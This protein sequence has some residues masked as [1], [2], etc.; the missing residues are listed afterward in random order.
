[1][2]KDG[3][4]SLDMGNVKILSK[5]EAEIPLSLMDVGDVFRSLF[6]DFF[7]GNG[8]QLLSLIHI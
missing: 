2:S 6:P 4:P 7:I 1:M 5:S 3:K 8:L